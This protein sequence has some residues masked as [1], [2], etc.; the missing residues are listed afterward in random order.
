MC[1]IYQSSFTRNPTIYIVDFIA[2]YGR[3]PTP[4]ID[5]ILTM[6]KVRAEVSMVFI[7]KKINEKYFI[8]EKEISWEP[9]RICLLS[10]TANPANFHPNWAGFFMVMIFSIGSV[11]S[12]ALVHSIP[13]KAVLGRNPVYSA[14]FS[15]Q[16]VAKP[17]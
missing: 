8:N 1:V 2:I 4:P 13:F 15:A 10:S 11:C 16:M 12:L 17:V 3:Q 7:V 5:K 9:F 6:K 14:C